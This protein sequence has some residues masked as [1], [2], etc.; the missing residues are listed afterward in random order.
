M[1][2]RR[3]RSEHLFMPGDVVKLNASYEGSASTPP[4]WSA[5]WFA[6]RAV[7]DRV[8]AFREVGVVDRTATLLVVA[9]G[10]VRVCILQGTTLG[11]SLA[12]AF[13]VIVR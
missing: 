5:D 9:T 7:V 10:E 12:R 11:W 1:R 3:D 2:S 6:D 13:A 8:G 4:V